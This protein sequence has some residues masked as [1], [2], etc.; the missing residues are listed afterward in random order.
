M[1][2]KIKKSLSNLS[3]LSGGVYTDEEP[4][5]EAAETKA[6]SKSEP[7]Q[8]NM[9]SD[10]APGISASISLVEIE[11]K[12][13]PLEFEDTEQ[14][15]GGPSTN[16][17]G[18]RGRGRPKKSFSTNAKAKPKSEPKTEPDS[19][20]AIPASISFVEMENKMGPFKFDE[21]KEYNEDPPTAIKGNIGGGRPKKSDSAK[22]AKKGKMGKGR[23]KKSQTSKAKARRVITQTKS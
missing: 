23:P 16:K 15:N 21:T 20:P 5:S 9:E 13:D 1:L 18:K 6:E 22:A 12:M 7:I 10:S 19:A 14:F 11:N 17:K 4:K 8:P 3:K 2:G